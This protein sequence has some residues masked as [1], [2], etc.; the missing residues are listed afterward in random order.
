MVSFSEVKERVSIEMVCDLLG[1]KGKEVK[2]QSRSECPICEGDGK[3]SFV[4]TFPKQ[5]WYSFCCG[6]GGDC[7]EL[8]AAVKKVS[9]KDAARELAEK[10]HVPAIPDDRKNGDGDKL[11]PLPYLEPDHPSVA[12]VGFPLEV[13]AH[14]RIGFA[15]KGVMRGAVAVPL[16]D[17]RG[18]L[19]GYLGLEHPVRLPKTWHM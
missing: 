5:L 15:G 1:I 16:R 3:R 19:V 7:L 4:V 8:Y 11:H 10:F 9:T 17:E 14:L 2:G 12:A 13:A 18:K 6:K